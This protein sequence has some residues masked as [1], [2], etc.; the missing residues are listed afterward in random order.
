MC[1]L[2]RGLPSWSGSVTNRTVK[3]ADPPCIVAT[4]HKLTLNSAFSASVTLLEARPPG[5]AGAFSR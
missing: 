4:P 2:Y 5:P 1:L 3:N